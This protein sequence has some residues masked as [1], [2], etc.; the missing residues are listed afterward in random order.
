M[1]RVSQLRGSPPSTLAKL[2]TLCVDKLT[3]YE[4]K[5]ALELALVP[6]CQDRVAV[7]PLHSS[8]DVQSEKGGIDVSHWGDIVSNLWRVAMTVQYKTEDWNRLMPRLLL[9]QTLLNRI[10]EDGDAEWARRQVV[11]NVC[12]I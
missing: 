8:L 5:I 9:K 1:L 12:T 7:A 4:H 2:L 6:P 10:G 11:L 3:A